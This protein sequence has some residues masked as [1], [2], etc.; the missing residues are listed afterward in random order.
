[1]VAP[2]SV[3]SR[4]LGGSFLAGESCGAPLGAALAAGLSADP[5]FLS[6]FDTGTFVS[7][8]DHFCLY[9][10]TA[11]T[12]GRSGRASGGRRASASKNGGHGVPPRS[13]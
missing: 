7:G 10:S 4:Y 13:V 8:C 2:G 1:M 12:R 5:G 6:A 9:L 3:H 11:Q